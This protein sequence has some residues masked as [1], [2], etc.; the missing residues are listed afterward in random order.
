MSSEATI[1]IGGEKKTAWAY[2]IIYL[3]EKIEF[4]NFYCPYCEIPLHS[5]NI[6][7][8][9]EIV[10]SPHFYVGEKAHI[11]GCNG[12]II[13]TEDS[14]KKIINNTTLS[15]DMKFPEELVSRP[16]ERENGNINEPV[17]SPTPLTLEEIERRRQSAEKAGRSKATSYLLQAFIEAKH[18]IIKKAFDTYPNK[19]QI[20]A[21]NKAI[22][23]AL[24]A[25]TLKLDDSTN[26]KYAF[27]T[28]SYPYDKRRIYNGSA[29]VF[30]GKDCFILQGMIFKKSENKE[31]T[32][33]IIIPL[34][35]LHEGSPKYQHTIMTFLS[36]NLDS[37]NDIKFN[38]FG[39]AK[40]LNDKED[41]VEMEITSLDYVYLT[42]PQKN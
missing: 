20:Q 4:K 5:R 31:I 26:Y 34:N 42:K 9:G 24:L 37:T 6:N 23:D 14:S 12:E 1:K 19:S 35:L 13:N 27:R 22:E 18:I 30:L 10:R 15:K 21:R 8:D 28:M 40:F 41:E 38:C 32:F 3:S 29:K 2:R 16:P 39:L 36:E 7:V 33:S 17:T 25:M 11:G